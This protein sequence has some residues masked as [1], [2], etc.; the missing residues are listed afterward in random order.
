MYLKGA[1]VRWVALA[2]VLAVVEALGAAPAPVAAPIK[3]QIRPTRIYRT[4]VL[5]FDYLRDGTAPSLAL[6]RDAIFTNPKSMARYYQAASFGSLDIQG[7][8][9]DIPPPAPL[10][11]TG[12][13]ACWP[14]TDE[15]AL[16]A[17]IAA[18]VPLRNYQQVVYVVHRPAGIPNCA[19]GVSSLGPMTFNLSIGPITLSVARLG[20]PFYLAGDFS[21]TTQSTLAHELGHSLGVTFHANSYMCNDGQFLSQ[22][23]ISC[24]HYAYGDLFQV[25]GLRTQ[26][27]LFSSPIAER[28][29]WLPQSA[30]IQ[31]QSMGTYRLYAYGDPIPAS[32]TSARALKIILPTPVPFRTVTGATPEVSEL[33]FE[34]R[35]NV[36]FDYRFQRNIALAGGGNFTVPDTD[37]VIITGVVQGTTPGSY[38]TLLLPVQTIP[39][40]AYGQNSASNPYLRMGQ[41]IVIPLNGMRIEV[42]G[43]QT[44]ATPHWID[45]RISRP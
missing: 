4:A 9:F 34:F 18:G 8:V 41:S 22:N 23:F 7:E 11:G 24:T 31:G 12:W 38:Y 40:V 2:G 1:G 5:R 15:A 30:I 32:G 39:N 13:T 20:V 6:I 26:M 16:N 45:V 37:G 27:S 28:L 33:Y 10:F 17:A 3:P 36:G 44:A 43:I 25:M 42:V 14:A 19:G 29:G 35:R 21:Q